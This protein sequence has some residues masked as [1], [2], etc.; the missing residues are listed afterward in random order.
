MEKQTSTTAISKKN[1][2][3]RR[4]E[5]HRANTL[6][7]QEK[8]TSFLFLLIPTLILLVF[9]YYPAARLLE[10]SFSDWNGYS[11][12][13]DYVG[14]ENYL[15]IF[16]NKK[17]IRSFLNTLAY[18]VIAVIQTFLGLYFAIILTTNLRGRKFF[19]SLFFVPYVMNAVAVS[20]M[21][22]YMY[23]YETNP[24]NV[25]LTRLGLEEY[26]IRWL[27]TSYFS[28]FSLAF[29][30]LWCFTGYA[31]V[32]FI[33]ALQS[34]PKSHLEAADLDGANFWQKVRYMV[35]PEIRSVIG[36]CLF[37][38]LNGALQAY[39]FAFVITKG[40]PSGATE[41]FVSMSVKQAYDFSK[42]GK[43][44]AMGVVVLLVVIL[45]QMVQKKLVEKE[46]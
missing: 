12:D 32:L 46:G 20:F 28:N 18:V 5:R 29:I 17:V 1:R 43:A 36:I 31:M 8:R 21:F 25:L 37:L 14:F 40:G 19:R 35:I 22:N 6:R 11:P 42:Y 10:L 2:I 15:E 23:N 26:C 27:S 3:M 4:P 24:I 34:I 44:S 33:G 13:Y 16:Q 39:D 30:G 38:N 9:T 41:T 7:R 45:V